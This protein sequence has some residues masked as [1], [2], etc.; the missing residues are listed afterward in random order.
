MTIRR[1]DA[2]ALLGLATAT[3]AAAKGGKPGAVKFLHGVAS[4]DPRT[5]RVILWTRITPEQPGAQIAYRWRLNPVDRR[6]GGAKSGTGVTGPERDYTAKVDVTGLSP[7]RAYTYEFEAAGVTS[8]MG[9]TS[10]LP[11]GPVQDFV[12][13]FAS[14]SL[15]PNGYFNAYQAM[16]DLPRVDLMLHLGDYIYE[17]GGEKSYGMNSAVAAE[18]PHDPPHECLSLDDY[19]RRHAQYKTDPALQAAHARAPWILAWDDHE[20]ANDSYK[21][22]AEN[23]QP[24][25]EG[26]WATRKAA[27]LKAYFEWQP[28]REPKPGQSLA[29]AGERS[30]RIGDLA[31]LVMLETRLTARTKQLTYEADLPVVDGKAQVEPFLKKWNDP[32]HRM[33]STAQEAWLGRELESSV[34]GGQAWQV[35]ASGVVMGRLKPPNPKRDFTPE[36]LAGVAPATQRRIARMQ[37]VAD[38][39]LPYGLD[40]WDGYPADRERVYD[41]VKAAQAR[42]IVISGDSHAFWANELHD[43][44]GKRVA[45]EFG[46]TA[47]T[48]PGADEAFGFPS[49]PAFVKASPEV[50]FCDQAA[51]GFVRLTLRRGEAVG[52][53]MTVS[54]IAS[55]DFKTSVLKSFRITP[56]G[57]GLSGLK[58]L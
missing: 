19:R 46:G 17:Y 23:H 25:A 16:A 13:A 9:R 11:A 15:Y 55:K 41:R 51:R 10:T 35:I 1:R 53:L 6:A 2:L 18:R 42:P 54:T 43:A 48:S 31:T 38:A 36:Q 32:S 45:C 28:I 21:D 14:C 34:K 33:M 52:D 39:G 40:M 37:P 24:A 44:G 3:P 8:P 26:D 12:I 58:A 30:F 7:G 50:K 4:G 27:A 49:G 57:T 29:E 56:E 5:D 47:I 22:G 20:T